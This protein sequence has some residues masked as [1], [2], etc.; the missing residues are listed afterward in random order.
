MPQNYMDYSDDAC[1][2]IFTVGQ[3]SRIAAVMEL[4]PRRKSATQNGLCSTVVAGPPVAAFT[5]D[6]QEVLR[7][8]EVAFSDLSSNF[9]TKWNWTFENGDPNT[10]NLQN[11]HVTY[12]TAGTYRVTLVASNSLGDSAPLV[13]EGYI[14]VSTEGLCGTLTNFLPTYTPSILKL[15]AFGNYKGYLTGHNSAKSKALSEFFTNPQGYAY[16]SAVNIRFGK[17][18]STKDDAKIVVTVWNAR[19][20]QNGPGSVIERKEVLIKQIKDDIS[21][22]RPTHISFDRETPVFSRPFHVGVELTYGTDSVAVVSS[23]NGEATNSTSWV[24]ASTGNWSPYSIAYG[25]SISM[26]IAPEV[27]MMTSVQ[28]AAS[29]IYVS[30]GEEVVL[31]ARGATIFVW[32]TADNTIQNFPGPQLIVR[33]TATT[34]Y[35]TTG[36]GQDLC[37]D[38]ALTTIYVK[39]GSITEVEKTPE[40]TLTLSPNPGNGKC[41]LLFDSAYE[42][43]VVVESFDAYGRAIHH[44]ELIK[45]SGAMTHELDFTSHSAGLYLVRVT[46]GPSRNFI[47]WIN[48]GH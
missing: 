25:A 24:Q 12:S 8:G 31:N 15:S 33:P 18:I 23:A 46:A 38:I 27:G 43:N 19:G 17:A 30:P 7:G 36:S 48:S 13:K 20:A 14:T 34:T 32:S 3:K 37:N 10:S 5:S 45:Q 41:T 40:N 1:M 9:P 47:K 16:I 44:D 39:T 21:H 4:S 26:D 6:K 42:G 35:Q 28:V 29:K 22:S 11:P 2:N